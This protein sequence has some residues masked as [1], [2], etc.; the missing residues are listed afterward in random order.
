MVLSHGADK[1]TR[2]RAIREI[3]ALGGKIISTP[4][5]NQIRFPKPVSSEQ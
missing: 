5:G 3:E 2:E 1:K 4:Q